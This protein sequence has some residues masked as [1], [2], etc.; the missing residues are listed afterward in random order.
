[1]KRVLKLKTSVKNEIANMFTGNVFMEN[2]YSKHVSVLMLT[3]HQSPMHPLSRNAPPNPK[4]DYTQPTQIMNSNN[5]PQWQK[6]E[7]HCT[8]PALQ[9]IPLPRLSKAAISQL[10][11]SYKM[12]GPYPLLDDLLHQPPPLTSNSPPPPPPFNDVPMG[13]AGDHYISQAQC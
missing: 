8:I 5:E 3:Q 12:L 11:N 6:I 9:T 4:S 1:M 2:I 10:V 13:K 7:Y